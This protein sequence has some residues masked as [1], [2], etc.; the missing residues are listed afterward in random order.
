ML[1]AETIKQAQL[2]RKEQ[3]YQEAF[4]AAQQATQ[5]DP[6]NADGWWLACRVVPGSDFICLSGSRQLTTR[7]RCFL[8]SSWR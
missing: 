5:I 6:N 2:L 7:Y 3:R 1:A 8:N 4:G